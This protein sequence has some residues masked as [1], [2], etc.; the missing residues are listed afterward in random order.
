VPGPAQV[1]VGDQACRGWR[2]T[3][4]CGGPPSV[5]EGEVAELLLLRGKVFHLLRKGMEFLTSGHVTD[6]WAQLAWWQHDW[7][8]IE[9]DEI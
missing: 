9:S 5:G 2:H 1:L 6:R 8:A 3:S 7:Y 4:H